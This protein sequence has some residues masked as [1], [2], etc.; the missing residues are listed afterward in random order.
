MNVNVINSTDCFLS[1][2]K[3]GDMIRLECKEFIFEKSGDLTCF[4]FFGEVESR[5]TIRTLIKRLIKE[6]EKEEDH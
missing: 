6:L 2:E 5:R 3:V 4:K 1:C